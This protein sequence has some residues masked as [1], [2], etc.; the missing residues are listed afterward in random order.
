MHSRRAAAAA[1]V[2]L[3]LAL[4]ACGGD[5]EKSATNAARPPVTSP[6]TTDETWSIPD[7]SGTET[8]PDTETETSETETSETEAQTE[9]TETE[10][11]PSDGWRSEER[12][13]PPGGGLDPEDVLPD[14]VKCPEAYVG[15]GGGSG[16]PPVGAIPGSPGAEGPEELP[17]PHP[18]SRQ[19]SLNGFPCVEVPG[20]DTPIYPEV[21]PTATP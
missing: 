6:A 15:N 3:A 16:A 9:T 13:Q 18:C 5:E 21:P 2:T 19:E 8:T 7:Y 4:P 10:T 20:E 17:D 11:T 12:C 14:P 1:G